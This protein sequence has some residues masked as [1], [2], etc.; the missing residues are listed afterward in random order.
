MFNNVSGNIYQKVYVAAYIPD[1][2]L[3]D[4]SRNHSFMI[5]CLRL[6]MFSP[7]STNI[8]IVYK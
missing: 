7:A 3:W 1:E 4:N 2:K 5:K 6:Q 8:M